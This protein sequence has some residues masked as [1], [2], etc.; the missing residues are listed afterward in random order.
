MVLVKAYVLESAFIHTIFN[1]LLN[2]LTFFTVSQIGYRSMMRGSQSISDLT[3][4]T[5]TSRFMVNNPNP[6]QFSSGKQK[7]VSTKSI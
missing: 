6:S 3:N 2:N 4:T 5:D 7:N 1:F